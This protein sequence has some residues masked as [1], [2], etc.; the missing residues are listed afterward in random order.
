M[1]SALAPFILRILANAKFNKAGFFLLCGAW[2]ELFRM[3][4]N[5]L[6]M[7]AH[8]EMKTKSLIRAYLLGAFIAIIGTYFAVRGGSSE[9]IVPSVL[10]L[11]GSVM[12]FAMFAEMCK[13]LE[14]QKTSFG[15]GSAFLYSIPFFLMPL[16]YRFKN[17]LYV[18]L[19]A[20]MVCGTYF[21]FWQYKA[22]RHILAGPK[23]FPEKAR[24]ID[25]KSDMAV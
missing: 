18:S 20:V 23:I 3:T 13:T 21:I 4:T 6:A 14:I 25:A 12:V 24:L 10:V 5:I 11:S 2:V 19:I 8:A 16:L 1:V 22:N 9:I 7:A 15:L 17:N